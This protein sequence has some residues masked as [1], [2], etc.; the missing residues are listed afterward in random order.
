MPGSLCAVQVLAVF[1]AAE[2]RR[3]FWE[4][5]PRS[6]WKLRMVGSLEKARKY[7]EDPHIRVVITESELPGARGWKD[8]LEAARCAPGSPQVIVT[9]R[10]ADERLWAEV[11]NIGGFDVILKPFVEQELSYVIGLAWRSWRQQ[12][13][14]ALPAKALAASA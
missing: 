2:D 6:K 12:A 7:L 13:P 11:L 4:K 14:Y 9:S 8:V 10:L 5:F 3:S 1:P